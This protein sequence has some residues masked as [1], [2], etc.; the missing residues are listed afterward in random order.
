MIANDIVEKALDTAIAALSSLIRH[1]LQQE[2]EM[3]VV[4]RYQREKAMYESFKKR[5]SAQLITDQ[6]IKE[7][8]DAKS[9]KNS[10]DVEKPETVS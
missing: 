9:N 2:K 4:R 5:I 10:K 3:P 7:R 8:K 6:K 1:N